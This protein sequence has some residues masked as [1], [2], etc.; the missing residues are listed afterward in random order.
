[1]LAHQTQ[2]PRH[3]QIPTR[4]VDPHTPDTPYTPGR[5]LCTVL[6][7]I[8]QAGPPSLIKL[9]SIDNEIFLGSNKETIQQFYSD[10]YSL[11]LC[12]EIYLEKKTIYLS[13]YTEIWDC[14]IT[15]I[16]IANITVHII[17]TRFELG[18]KNI[19]DI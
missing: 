11:V 1:M 17:T 9:H 18:C 4:A 8:P 14:C 10:I 3:P 13:I 16:M 12:T 19:S 2:H 15:F 7:T 6:V 5:V